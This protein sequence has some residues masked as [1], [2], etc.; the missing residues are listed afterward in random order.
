MNKTLP[1]TAPASF[2]LATMQKPSLAILTSRI[3]R[4]ARISLAA[5]TARTARISRTTLAS[6]LLLAATSPLHLAAQLLVMQPRAPE[7]LVPLPLREVRASGWMREQILRDI[8]SGY[9]S[10]YDRLQ[11]TMRENAYGPQK[12]KNFAIGKNGQWEN[13]RETWW[14][15]EHEGYFAD[16]V[17]R[18]A[19][20]SGYKPW[21]DKARKILDDVIKNQDATGYIGLYDAECRLSSLLNENGEF[22]TQSRILDALLAFYEYTGEQKYFD[23]VKRALNC[24]LSSYEKS[25]KTYFQQPKPNGGGLTHGLM[26]GETLEWMH[27]LTGDARYLRFT[28]WLYKDYSAAEPKLTNVDNQLGNLLQRE[29]PYLEHSVHVVEGERVVYWLASATRKA[30]Y[31]EA[32]ANSIHKYRLA[33]APTGAIVIDPAQHERVAGNHGSPDLGYEYCSITEGVQSFNSALRKF[34]DATFGDEVEKIAFNAG[35]GARLPDGKAISYSTSD[36]RYDALMAKDF[37]NQVAACHSVACCNLQAP[38]LLP[39]YI[40]GMWLKNAAADTLYA[41]LYGPVQ[42]TTTVAGVKVAID[43][44]TL[45]PFEG[46]VT[47]DI[48]PETEKEFAIVLRNPSWSK[49]TKVTSPGAKISPV[50]DGYITVRK[51]WAKGDKI[52]IEFDQQITLKR[53]GNN[54][55]YITRGPLIYAMKI[56]EKRTATK[57]FENG[58]AN[59]DVTPANPETA[60]KIYNTYRM[61]PNADIR[62]ARNATLFQYEKNPGADPQHPFDKP[63]GFIKGRF[64]ENGNYFDG[65]LVPIGSTVLRRETFRE[66]DR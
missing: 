18:N 1:I 22:W 39:S 10:V 49:N 23:A 7:A 32:A 4:T 20:L 43:E 3:S 37:R 44:K 47:L 54:E 40:D 27:R 51:T 41:M 29:K 14:P 48:T 9:I 34:R 65:T 17:V 66:A 31:L 13:R 55:F 15:G 62:F 42:V 56:D 38:K 60:K 24:T 2:E 61:P 33:Q 50:E 53:A 63:W 5:R 26:L 58:L 36:N 30:P 6:L 59:Y 25:G 46:A 8:T 57:K 21:Q 12:T 45:Y 52:G 16:V 64:A 28:E 11:P 19:F 35:Q